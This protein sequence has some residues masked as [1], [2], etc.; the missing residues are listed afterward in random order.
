EEIKKAVEDV[1]GL[2]EMTS[3]YHESGTD[4]VAEVASRFDD[5]A[6]ILNVQGDLPQ[7]EPNIGSCL[8]ETLKKRESIEI[9]TP[10]RAETS[11]YEMRNPNNVKAIFDLDG[12]ALFFSRFPIGA[13][14]NLWFRHIGV[15]AYH[16]R[17]LQQLSNFAPT[18][19]EKVEKLEQMRALE[20]AFNFHCMV[21]ID[22]CGADINVPDDLRR[23]NE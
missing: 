20:Y 2:V 16:N 14:N 6:I 12:R 1:G 3:K 21:T 11:E 17:A 5:D 15:Y 22:N 4:R 10:V 9:A 7:F 13:G 18:A 8:I 23:I 19:L